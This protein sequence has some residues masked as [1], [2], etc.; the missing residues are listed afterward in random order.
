MNTDQGDI[1]PFVRQE[2]ARLGLQLHHEIDGPTLDVWLKRDNKGMRERD[3]E[4]LER[5]ARER[6]EIVASSR[7]LC[8]QLVLNLLRAAE[9]ADAA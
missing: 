6:D 4:V 3:P 8:R 5:L 7:A 1:Y 9:Q 2:R